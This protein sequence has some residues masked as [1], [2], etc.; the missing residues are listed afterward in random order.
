[1]PRKITQT[2]KPSTVHRL[3]EELFKYTV[4]TGY[5]FTGFS[6]LMLYEVTVSGGEHE[7]LPFGLALVKALV[8]GKFLLIGEALKAGSLAETHPLLH[9]VVWKSLAFLGVL[10]VF[11][12][13]EEI[14]VGWFHN[15]P[16]AQVVREVLERSL[17][18]N[19]APIL[20]MLLIL[21]PLI[22]ISEIYRELGKERFKQ[23]WLKRPS[24]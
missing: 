9:R 22:C 24:Q 21:I 11:T 17:L 19:M 10:A 18:E 3:K 2:E 13:L 4:V 20:V 1:M 6:L 5:L 12:A 16:S 15:K 8:L 14:V 7:A 23:L